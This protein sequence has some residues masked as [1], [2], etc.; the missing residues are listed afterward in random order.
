MIPISTQEELL[1]VTNNLSGS[2]VLTADID[3]VGE[4][5][6]SPSRTTSRAAM[7]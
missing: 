4:R 1:A 6:C 3:F 2:Y 7:C 5:N